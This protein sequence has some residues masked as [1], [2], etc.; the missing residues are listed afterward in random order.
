M[1]DMNPEAVAQYLAYLKAKDSE[2][3]KLIKEVEHYV[4]KGE[5]LLVKRYTEHHPDLTKPQTRF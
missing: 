5:S 3:H 4:E 2:L 1:N